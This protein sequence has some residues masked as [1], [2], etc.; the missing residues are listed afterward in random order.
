MARLDRFPPHDVSGPVNVRWDVRPLH[1][2]NEFKFAQLSRS[3]PLYDMLHLDGGTVHGFRFVGK[4]SARFFL[5]CRHLFFVK[6]F[7]TT[8][9][10]D[11]K[12]RRWNPTQR[13]N[14]KKT[15][16]RKLCDECRNGKLYNI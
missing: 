8:K 13:M 16:G 4:R 10:M 11:R 2:G 12:L 3:P 14:V 7:D 1:E 6:R 9:Q 5:G 15:T